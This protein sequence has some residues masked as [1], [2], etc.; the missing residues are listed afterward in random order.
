MQII[1]E[2]HHPINL[3]HRIIAYRMNEASPQLFGP[4]ALQVIL[5]LEL[6]FVSISQRS[7]QVCQIERPQMRNISSA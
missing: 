1:I 2:S 4:L 6:E 5:N 3:S 7:K